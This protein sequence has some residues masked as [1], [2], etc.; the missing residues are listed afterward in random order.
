MGPGGQHS[1]SLGKIKMDS[2][3]MIPRKR[4]WQHFFLDVMDYSLSSLLYIFMTH[5]NLCCVRTTS[6]ITLSGTGLQGCY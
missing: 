5:G 1:S 3:G 4:T 6:H 2:Q